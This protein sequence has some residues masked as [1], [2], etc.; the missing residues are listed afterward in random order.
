MQEISVTKKRFTLIRCL[1]EEDIM[2]L[3]ADQ[4]KQYDEM[5]RVKDLVTDDFLKRPD[6]TGIGVGL[7]QV[8]GKLTDELAIIISVKEKKDV[9]AE[10]AI[11]AHIKGFVTDVLEFNPTTKPEISPTEHEDEQ[12]GILGDPDT[13]RYSELMGGMSISLKR[14]T[15]SGTLGLIVKKGKLPMLLT[16]FHVITEGKTLG[17]LP[18]YEIC[19]PSRGDDP[20]NYDNNVCGTF[21]SAVYQGNHN[22]M[23][24]VDCAIARIKD[25]FI[26]QTNILDVGYTCGAKTLVKEDLGKK[27]CKRGRTT[28]LTNGRINSID[29][30]TK[31]NSVDFY[32]QV[33][34]VPLDSNKDFSQPGDSGS[35]IFLDGSRK[36]IALLWGGVEGDYSVASPIDA[37]MAALQITLDE[38][39]IMCD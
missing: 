25:R 31:N 11:P 15:S 9:P 33:T 23:G 6:V 27:V 4:E 26:M 28:K 1:A 8:K 16:N 18:G 29:F 24:G 32:K 7:K 3:D 37:V 21:N 5:C 35:V 38:D 14:L 34:V 20:D 19:Q 17:F 36:I 39:L 12:K 2:D 13:S 22:N 30:T 10:I